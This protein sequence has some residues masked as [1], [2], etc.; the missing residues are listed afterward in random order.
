MKR[1]TIRKH[2]GLVVLAAGLI[3]LAT[4][5]AHA[6]TITVVNLDGARRR[7]QRSDGR[8]RPKAGTPGPRSERSGSTRST[9]PPTAGKPSS[10]AASPSW[11]TAPSTTSL[12][13]GGGGA[14][15]GF[16]GPN[17]VHR[18]F[19]GAP[20]ASTWFSQAQANSLNGSD[21]APADRRSQRDIQQ[22]HRQRLLARHHRLVLRVRRQQPR[23]NRST[24]CRRSFTRWRTVSDFSR[25]SIWPSGAK[26]VGFD[27]IYMRFLEDHST[28]IAL[29]GH[30]QRPARQR[31]AST[32]GTCTGSGANVAAASGL[33]SAGKTGTHVHMYAPNPQEPGSS[34]SH[35]DT[36]L[37]PD[38]LMEPFDTGTSFQSHDR[39]RSSIDIGWTRDSAAHADADRDP[40]ADATPTPTP[41]ADADLRHGTDCGLSH[42]GG[43]AE[44]LA[45]TERSARRQQG[46]ADL[47]VDQGLRDVEGPRLRDPAHL[48]RLP[49]LH[50]RRH[51]DQDRERARA[52]EPAL[53][54]LEPDAVLGGQADRLQ[55]QGQGSHAAM[56]C[57]RSS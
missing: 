30:E 14:L 20:V 16:A 54:R 10:R 56:A 33:L 3:F 6:T 15:L 46:Q 21:L 50:L 12:P 9:R 7:L 8:G 11:W 53:Q 17:T 40:H 38:E 44:S 48:D 5:A 43:R 55:V 49:A 26:F 1:R 25:S 28:G 31:R 22:R 32:P 23:R 42:A 45:P 41:D 4:T 52:R 34:V 13:C 29:P 37:T 57:S 47:E 27:D 2:K 36:T 19:V 39:S 51:V 35:W 18:D 24:S